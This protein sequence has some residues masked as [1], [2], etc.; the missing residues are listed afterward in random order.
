LNVLS[1]LCCEKIFEYQERKWIVS[2]KEKS[3]LEKQSKIQH[4]EGLLQLI[5]DLEAKEIPKNSIIIANQTQTQ[6]SD[7]SKAPKE[8]KRNERRGR[9]RGRGQFAKK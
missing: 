8:S 6:Q 1:F 7:N 2:Q 5:K 3:L 9:G 4:S